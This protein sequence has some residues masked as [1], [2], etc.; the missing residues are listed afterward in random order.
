MAKTRAAVRIIGLPE[1][2]RQFRALP[3]AVARKVIRQGLRAGAKIIRDEA[4]VRSPVDE[5]LLRSSLR[6]RAAKVRKKNAFAVLVTTGVGF[7]TGEAFYGAFVEFGTERMEGRHFIQGAF[8][9]KELT[10]RN[11]ALEV[12]KSG[13][14]REAGALRRKGR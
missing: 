3:A 10:A 14:V 5:G 6:V 11:V 2:N 13:I 1:L 12:I 7:F 9:A 8:Q 4:M